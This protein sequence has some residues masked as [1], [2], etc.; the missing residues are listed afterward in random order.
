MRLFIAEKPSMGAEIAKV[1]AEI[2]DSKINRKDGFIQTAK[3]IITWQFGHLLEL[4]SPEEISEEYKVW[5]F[6]SLPIIPNNFEKIVKDS[7]KKQFEII[8]SLIHN[9]K[10]TEIIHAGDP[11]REGELLIREVLYAT[12]NKKSVK[13]ILLNA[14][15]NKSI[16]FALNDLKND[17]VF[18]NL[19]NSAE[20]RT[21]ADWLIG[22]NLTR[23]YT[24][25]MRKA[26]F[27]KVAN[28]GRVMTPTMCLVIN[29][30]EEINKFKP[31]LHY[32]L[33]VSFQH[34]NGT[35]KT[36]LRL[37]KDSTLMNADGYILDKQSLLDI[38]SEL[39]AL[40][41]ADISIG[42][43]K[44]VQK[45]EKQRLPYS[46]S[47]LQIEAGKKYGY[48]PQKVLDICQNLY[49]KKIT[50]YPRSDC[51]YLPENQYRNALPILKQ[52][53]TDVYLKKIAIGVDVKIKSPAWNDSKITAHH[54]IIPTGVIKDI[55]SLD[56]DSLNIYRMIAIAYI[57]QFYPVCVYNQTTI[58]VTIKNK[59][60]EFITTGK[61]IITMGWKTLF[62]KETNEIILPTCAKGDKLV[63]ITS[64]IKEDTTKPPKR[65][66]TATLLE[67]MKNINK[68]VVN[69]KL[70]Q[71]LKTTS[72]IGTEA[73]RA[74]IID[75]LF[76]KGFLKLDKKIIIP[77]Q[78][79]YHLEKILPRA[80]KEPDL[81][82]IWEDQ[83]AQ[84]AEGSLDIRKFNDGQRQFVVKVVDFAK[85]LKVEPY[86][87]K[88]TPVCPYCGSPLKLIKTKKGTKVFMCS[89]INNCKKGFFS[90]YA[91]K[92]VIL[93]CPKCKKGY[94]KQ[95]EGTKG[96]FWACDNYPNCKYVLP[97]ANGKPCKAKI[98]NKTR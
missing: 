93:K 13:R 36:K 19:Y 20:A 73:T 49:E 64:T 75:K 3:S 25:A 38:Q 55:S 46:L 16:K 24:L 85:T 35:I 31:I 56:E 95:K 57:A 18:D 48:S 87:D 10:I 4:K 11:D 89:N 82:A 45:T 60:Y 70:K 7:C 65:F 30:E 98:K 53:A 41:P 77:T 12:G 47:T 92:P 88:E 23:A 51:N 9:D 76:E 69:T 27:D 90:C 44:I 15:D 1:I 86:I 59:S 97:D 21:E 63:Y 5:S 94:L 74:G 26:G 54:A 6:S 96:K 78:L 68:Y 83:L 81:T 42:E 79:A 62:A 80:I 29:R 58:I 28:I 52:L 22:M 61:S 32:N 50:S 43:Y 84:I 72:G 40:N 37:P 67:A 14:L 17:A 34:Q 39:K 91:N 8:K 66:T 2:E 33:N 71:L